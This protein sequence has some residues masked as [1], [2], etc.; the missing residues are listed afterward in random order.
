[1]ARIVAVT[2][3]T[4]FIGSHVVRQLAGNGWTV[5][6]LT[7]RIPGDHHFP[8]PLIEAVVGDLSDAAALRRLVAGAEVV[9]HLAGL[10]KAPSAQAFH[11]VNAMG[12]RALVQA[13][14]TQPDAR[15]IH[16]SSL[17]VREP[18]ISDYAASKAQA[19]NEL[20]TLSNRMAWTIIRPSVV[21]GPGDRETLGFFQTAARGFTV[22][23]GPMSQKISFIYISDLSS[24]INILVQNT[25]RCRETLEVDDGK[26][27]GYSWPEIAAAMGAAAGRRLRTVHLPAP[28]VRTAATVNAAA[29]WLMGKT[30]MFTPGK[31]REL[32]YRDW[33]A[34]MPPGG[35]PEWR[36]AHGLA[37]GFEKAMRWYR[38]VGWL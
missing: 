17:V 19:E 7:R 24:L 8:L 25:G 31:A 22:I 29:H 35:L 2:G 3:A 38:S 34:H 30:T 10:V 21:Y 1:M 16:V 14:L 26:L 28:A 12:T 15:L 4:G 37:E 5:R 6:I 33:A 13:V 20:R 9:V 27:G 32:T 18:G 36:P 23:P 11:R